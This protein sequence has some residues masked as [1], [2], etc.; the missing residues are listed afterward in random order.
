MNSDWTEFH[1]LILV[2]NSLIESPGA[3]QFSR[4]S[5]TGDSS[6]IHSR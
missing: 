2:C 4:A 1:E 5:L 6:K 3:D